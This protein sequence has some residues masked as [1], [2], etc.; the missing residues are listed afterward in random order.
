[1]YCKS[2]ISP[3]LPQFKANLHSHS[4]LSD[5]RL[6]PEDM[7]KA[8]KARG[9]SILAITDHEA[10]YDH[11]DLSTP[12]FLMLTGYEAYIRPS[13]NCQLDVYGPEIHL[14]LLAKEPHNTCF[15][16][17]D[18]NFCKYMPHGLA[19]S[20][21]QAGNIGPRRYDRE[22][23]R[24]FIQEANKA[25]YLVTYNHPNWSMEEPEEILHYDGFFSL[26][27]FNTGSMVINGHE[28][29]LGLY[30]RLL[31]H[32]K[33]PYVHGA[34]DNHNKRPFGDPLC[35]SF[36]AWT[37]IIAPELSYPAII[38]ALEKGDFYASTGPEIRELRF[39]DK[40]VTLR[41]SDA[42][43]IIMHMSPKR[44]QNVCARPGETV[45]QAEFNIPDGAPYVYFS[46]FGPDGTEAHTRAYP[47]GETNVCRAG[48]GE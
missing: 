3:D 13:P 9:Y 29:N 24:R 19:E 16:A 11:T 6:T 34:D 45:D 5:G 1:M 38:R 48:E 15:V 18:P 30:D 23:I 27:I 12:D 10:P 20:R 22:Y 31:R 35:D 2:P 32:G 44:T 41:C 14:N 26:E 36:G 39:E 4:N 28:N 46:V 8:Y 21:E 17:Y 40:H 33:F 25:G 42:R 43:R 7:V 47:L 37:M